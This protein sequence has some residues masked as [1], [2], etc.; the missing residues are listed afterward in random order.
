MALVKNSEFILLLNNDTIVHPGTIAACLKAIK[1]DPG[2]GVM[3]CLLKNPDGSMQNA[4]RKFP[5]PVR[6]VVSSLGLPWKLPRLFAW[7]DIEDAGWDRL[8]VKRD[9]DWLGGAF[10]F[11]RAA[12]LSE[13]GLLDEDFFFGGEDVEFCH[14]VWKAGYRCHYDPAAAITHIGGRSSGPETTLPKQQSRYMLQRRCYG[15]WAALVL[16]ATDRLAGLLRSRK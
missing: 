4:A 3:S 5:T 13:T 8:K 2:I 14:R 9:V 12:I 10:L 7:A 16:R 11:I 1:N 15:S 6:A